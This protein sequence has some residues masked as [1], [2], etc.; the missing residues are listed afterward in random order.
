[1]FC[2]E[3]EIQ[4]GQ[5]NQINWIGASTGVRILSEGREALAG[6]AEYNVKDDEFVLKDN[7]RILDGKNMLMGEKIRFWRESQR[8]ICEPSARVVVYSDNKMT[9]NFFEK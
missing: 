8:M 9:T 6:K 4:T 7:P 1:M 2:D 5:D 3:L